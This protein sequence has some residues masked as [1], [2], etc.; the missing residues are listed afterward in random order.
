M[1]SDQKMCKIRNMVKNLTVFDA[2]EQVLGTSWGDMHSMLDWITAARRHV[3]PSLDLTQ[4]EASAKW[5]SLQETIQLARKLGVLYF[6][7]NQ[8]P[9]P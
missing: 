5:N 4:F 3:V 8:V 6:T 7:Y 1:L 2:L 9:T